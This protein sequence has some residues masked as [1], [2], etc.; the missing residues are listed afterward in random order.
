M[1]GVR[2]REVGLEV[3]REPAVS[4]MSRRK[5]QV[6]WDFGL[7]PGESAATIA[8]GLEVPVGAGR[9]VLVSGPSG[10][11]KTT[12]LRALAERLR[13]AA[14]VDAAR[15][16]GRRAVVDLV[17]P[18]GPL[19][20][21]VELL[22]SC[23]VGEPRLWL[24]CY[25]DLS[26]GEQLR[27]DFA[28]AIGRWM[29]RR[30]ILC[31]EFGTCLHRRAARA[32][33]HHLRRLATRRGLAVVVATAHED[34]AGDL[35]PDEWVRLRPG[36]GEVRRPGVVPG[37]SLSVLRGSVIEAGH[38]A[39][40]AAFSAMHYRQREQ[41]GFV[42]KVF[43]LRE[44]PGGEALAIVVYAHGPL[45]LAPRNRATRG[46]FVNDPRRLNREVRILRRLVVHP[47][48]RGCG[49]GHLLVRETLGRVGVR[50]VECLARLGTVVPVFERAGMRA[51]G[52]CPVPRGRGRLLERMCRLKLDPFGGDLAE[53]I[54]RQPRVRRLVERTIR[55][56]AGRTHSAAARR[57]PG[58]GGGGR[59]EA[60]RQIIGPPPM[61]YL[62]DR[63]GEFPA[64][65]G[66][67]GRSPA[68]PGSRRESE[69]DR[70]EDERE[71]HRP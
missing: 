43:V 19:D 30:P 31:D 26:A 69:G 4:A 13:P 18:R 58:N 15:R 22:A 16:P 51:V 67:G 37:R 9:I 12:V 46:R 52:P 17:S 49:A 23:G 54:A 6:C 57:R 39:D 63:E 25:R 70:R 20:R 62:W 56:W 1:S 65:S 2:P 61:Y 10:S 32:A 28:R 33:A 55:E 5:R 53:R 7:P 24:R 36:G 42:D 68:G 64:G 29:G 21:A 8:A 60:F 34:I 41:L 50:F 40:Y 11:G 35:Q 45:E 38:V 3:I 48:V 47:D 71:R 59:A 44:A 27:V 66:D 14:W